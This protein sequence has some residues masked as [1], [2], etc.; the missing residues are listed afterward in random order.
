MATC[1]KYVELNPVRAEIVDDPA[2]YRFSTYGIWQQSG[3]HP[4]AVSFK[5]HMIPALRVYLKNESMKG[6][7][8][9]FKER[10]A[11]ICA[12]ESGGDM[13]E[14]NLAVKR[15]NVRK[16]H[17]FLVRSRFWIDS[18]VLG[19]RTALMEHAADFWGEDRAQ[20]KKFGRAYE[21]DGTEILS[22]RQL[23]VD[24]N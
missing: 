9:Y 5:N 22:L 4:Y 24:V 17:P 21:E 15:A 18:V 16:K 11:G 6:L 1:L 14:V 23:M 7:E 10:F 20:R 8:V 19:T 13:V 3:K 12:S 2:D